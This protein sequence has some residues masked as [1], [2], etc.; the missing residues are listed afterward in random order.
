MK[1]MVATIL[2]LLNLS[3]TPAIGADTQK[4]LDAYLNGD[5]ATAMSEWKPLAEQGDVSAQYNLG[6]LYESGLGV[7]QDAFEAVKWYRLAADQGDA[8]AQYNLGVI[9]DEGHGVPQDYTKAVKWYKLAAEQGDA[10]AQSNLGVMYDN[11][12]GVPHDHITAYM[13]FSIAASMGNKL[14][15]KNKD[16]IAKTMSSDDIDKAQAM[17]RECMDRDH[18]NCSGV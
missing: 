16:E 4:G 1:H 18:K 14:A 2:T 7:V 5:Y 9:Y 17:V 3:L 15:L 10:S 12:W 8:S 11:G 6:L 13:W